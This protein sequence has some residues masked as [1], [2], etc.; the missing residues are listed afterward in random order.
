MSR[1]MQSDK[2]DKIKIKLEKSKRTLNKLKW[3]PKKSPSKKIQAKN[4]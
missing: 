3:W 1:R 4:I 2:F